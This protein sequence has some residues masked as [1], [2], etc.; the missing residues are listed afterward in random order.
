M[1]EKKI[2]FTLIR[3]FNA[4]YTFS[5]N[6]GIGIG[7]SIF[8]QLE[9]N[10]KLDLIGLGIYS[11]VNIDLQGHDKFSIDWGFIPSAWMVLLAG[12]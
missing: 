8:V 5:A 7:T 3:N 12:T 9:Q 6:M 2:K 1:G 10:K 11:T 4:P